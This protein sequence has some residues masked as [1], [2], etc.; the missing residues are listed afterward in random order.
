MKDQNNTLRWGPKYLFLSFFGSGYA[1]KAPGTFGSLA[2]IPFIY[3]LS[4]L[5][6]SFVSLIIATIII[7]ILAC[8][9]ADKV[10]R[11]D[12]IFD[13]GWIVIDE[14]VGMLI[15]WMFVFPSTSLW[16]IL[17]VFGVF[18]IFDIVKIWPASFFDKKMK[19]G[20][21]TIFDDVISAIYA[22]FFLWALNHFHLIN[23]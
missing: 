11:E 1:P 22:G 3:A 6:I 13:P 23:S 18:R 20:F 5:G 8:L 16:N 17:L 10:Q 15:T 14:V 21:A 2:T 4:Y 19:N 12:G 9:V 7:F